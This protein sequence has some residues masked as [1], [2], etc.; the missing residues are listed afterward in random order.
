MKPCSFNGVYQPSLLDSFP[1]RRVLPLSYFYDR[2]SP[3]VPPSKLNVDETI[4]CGC[5]CK[6][7]DNVHGKRTSPVLAGE[8]DAGNGTKHE[9]VP[10]L[11]LILLLLRLQVKGKALARQQQHVRKGYSLE[12]RSVL[13]IR[14]QEG[15]A[16]FRIARDRSVDDGGNFLKK[17]N[18]RSSG[19]LEDTIEE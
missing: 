5:C 19:F 1:Y 12:R 11:D 17:D 3:L 16:N 4:C 10:S 2:L 6:W 14:H 9:F 18:V 13:G 7:G 8:F 15:F